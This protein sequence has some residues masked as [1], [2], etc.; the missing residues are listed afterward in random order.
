MTVGHGRSALLGRRSECD[1]SIGLLGDAAGRQERDAGPA[2]RGRRR[3]DRA[4][5]VRWSSGPS[6]CRVA[7]AAGVE[8]EMELAVRRAAPAVRADARPARAAARS[9]ARRARR[10]VRAER[11]APRRTGSWSG[12][13][14]SACCPR[15]PR[16]GRCCASST[17]RSGWTGRR[18]RR[19][20]SWRAGCW[21]SRSRWCSRR[22]RPTRRARRA[23]GAAWSRVCA[24]ATRATL[25]ASVIRGPLDER[26]RDRIVAETR[27]NPLALL[28]LPRGLTPAELAG[29]F[30][31]PDA[32]PLSGRIEESFRRRLDGAARPRRGGCCWSRRPSR[33]ASRCC[34][35]AR[36]SGSGI[37]AEA[38]AP[39]ATAGLLEFGARV[40]FRHP[41]VRSAVYRAASPSERQS[42][43]GALAEATDPEVDPDRRAWHRAQAAPGP[44]RTSPRSSSARPAGAQARGGLAAA[45]AFLERAAELTPDPARRA[46]ARAGRGAGQAPGRRARRGARAAG[47]RRGRAARRAP[48]RAGRP[49]ARPDRVRRAA[50]AATRRRC[51]SR[52]PGG[53]SRSTPRSRARPTWTRSPRRCSPAALA[54]AAA[55]GRWP[56]AARAAPPPSQPPR[57]AD[58]LLDGLAL[59]ITDGYAA[60]A[61]MLQRALSAFRSEDLSGR[62]GLRWLWLACRIAAADLWDDESWDVLASPPGPA[63]ARRRRARRA[64]PRAQHTACALAHLRR[65][66]RRGRV[67][68]RG[69][70]R[71]SPRRP[72]SPTSRRTAR[73]CSP[74]G[75]AA[76]AEAAA[77]IEATMQDAIARGEGI[78]LVGRRA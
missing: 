44:T 52:P 63:R 17:T 72:G 39:A 68:G 46:R 67:A 62:G 54:A 50:A 20:R 76:E 18:R 74:P 7:R 26:V 22:A 34:C 69:G 9:A 42:V 65:R 45:A 75:G 48:A 70:A 12:W 35:G 56:Q 73:C 32:L 14:C 29:G 27:G 28:E 2:R 49:A 33:S 40:R 1:A 25:L 23:A 43:H 6:G 24:T 59:L 10:G 64:S 77:L 71:R 8:S 58:L 78:G 61:P 19:S 60:G 31:L 30:G 57:A 53:S 13:R 41:L 15:W 3:Q 36:P 66:V 47:H 37:G 16:S 4:A 21:R 5:G 38:A 11:R 51:C 55:C